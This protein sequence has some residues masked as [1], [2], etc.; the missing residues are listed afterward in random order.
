[1]FDEYLW[2][3]EEGT[4]EW[5]SPIESYKNSS[6]A[7]TGTPEYSRVEYTGEELSSI[8]SRLTGVFPGIGIFYTA[9]KLIISIDTTVDKVKSYEYI[10]GRKLEDDT[11]DPDH[12]SDVQYFHLYPSSWKPVVYQTTDQQGFH[13]IE[14]QVWGAAANKINKEINE[15]IYTKV[16][17]PVAS[18]LSNYFEVD[19]NGHYRYTKDTSIVAGKDYYTHN[20]LV[21]VLVNTGDMT[22]NGTRINEWL[23][24]FIGAKSLVNHLE[25]MCIVGNNDLC[26][27]NVSILGTGDDVGKSNSYYFHVFYCYQTFNLSLSG[28]TTDECGAYEPNYN[29]SEQTITDIKPIVNG[30]YVPSL[31]YFTIGD[32]GFAM[33]NSEITY[34]NCRDWFGLVRDDKVY[35]IYTGWEVSDTSDSGE[36][37]TFINNGNTKNFTTVYTMICAILK[38]I[39][40]KY[41]ICMC[42]EM[43]FT[44]MTT[45]C[46]STAEGVTVQYKRFRSQSDASSPA[47]IGSHLNQLTAHD[48]GRGIYWFSRLLEKLG[49]KLVIGGHKHTFACTWPLAENYLSGSTNAVGEATLLRDNII[50]FAN[51]YKIAKDTVK[52]GA[53]LTKFPKADCPS[54]Y[55]NDTS[56]YIDPIQRD[57]TVSGKVTYFMCQATGY[58]LTSNKELP[59][60]QQLFS[61]FLPKTTGGAGDKPAADQKYPMFSRID[62]DN[63]NATIYLSRVE[64]IMKSGAFNQTTYLSGDMYL[65]YGQSVYRNCTEEELATITGTTIQSRFSEVWPETETKL[66][67]VKL[68][69]I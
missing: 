42:H 17:S 68:N 39:R 51:N 38:H 37:Q 12:T 2:I 6:S 61:R 20:Q 50:W 22:Q 54:G 58:K 67:T 29:E 28:V 27:T 57:T 10:V 60:V 56:D 55:T 33:I 41:T 64:N 18:G 19:K 9:H 36:N 40:N 47:L 65:T 8:Y 63:G 7:F 44:V 21:P 46:M 1:L 59:G 49:I 25:Y 66:L 4:D 15:K 3:R 5:S 30:K 48:T 24:H 45:G 62:L 16:T 53:N 34:V 35:N 43:P 23:D 32:Y 26:G 14:Y 31:Y 11:P 52:N 13:W 69:S